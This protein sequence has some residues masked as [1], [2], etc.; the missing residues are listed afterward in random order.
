MKVEMT[1]LPDVLVVTPD[2]RGD[3]RGSFHEAWQLARY[4]EAGLPTRWVQ[5]NVSRSR[6]GVLR[7]LHFQHPHGQG[8]LLSALAGEIID[9]AVDVRR[10]SP[11]FGRG[12]SVSLSSDNHRQLYVPAGFAHGFLVVS[13]EATVSYKCTDYYRA[14]LE[15]VIAWNDPALALTWP[16]ADPIV[17]AKDAAAH[18]LGQLP[19][20]ALPEYGAGA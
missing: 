13:E 1:T 11:T 6:R 3:A 5:D 10:G 14:E 8:K 12:V 16:C 4:A 19:L 7:G 20:H 18:R 9:V 2:V 15:Q 17:S